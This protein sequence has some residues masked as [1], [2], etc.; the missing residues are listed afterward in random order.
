[1]IR[2]MTAFGSATQTDTLGT[3]ALEL[4]SV[5]SRYLDLHFRLPEDIRHLETGCRER[6]QAALQRGKV[7]IRANLQRA[8]HAGAADLNT[9]ALQAL[10]ATLRQVQAVVPDVQA[11]RLAEV[12][13]WPGV[14]AESDADTTWDAAVYTA[15]DAAVTQLQASRNDEG[16][17]LARAML[18]LVE[19]IEA[20]A[21]ALQAEMPRILE[22]YRERQARKLRDTF[23][24]AFPQG[25][26]HISGTEISERL[27]HETALF[28]LR[29]DVAEEL[30]RLRSHLEELRHI[31]GGPDRNAGRP[32]SGA[33][34]GKNTGSTGKRLDFLLQE[35]NREANTLGSKAGAIDMTRAALDLKLLIEQ[36]REQAQN[37]E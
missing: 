25:L 24:A 37:I 30:T 5:N 16:A 34:R 19:Q 17:R 3:V 23:E 14:Q 36:L 12:L 32:T 6:L 27:A 10:A 31:L 26:Q 15:L 13:A 4:R 20:I 35:M 8:P 11:P 21:D 29:I 2:S 22:A 1:M 33:K 7:E 18:E 9:E 28:S